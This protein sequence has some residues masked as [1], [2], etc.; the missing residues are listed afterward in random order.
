MPG[1][2]AGCKEGS[3]RDWCL[4]LLFF[5]IFLCGGKVWAWEGPNSREE[6]LPEKRGNKETKWAGLVPGGICVAFILKQLLAL[7]L[8]RRCRRNALLCQ[9]S[10]GTGTCRGWG[11]CPQR[12]RN[13]QNPVEWRW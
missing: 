3:G 10:T 6:A 13:F 12:L 11:L 7:A 5:I 9:P 4:V 2:V 8:A 1:T